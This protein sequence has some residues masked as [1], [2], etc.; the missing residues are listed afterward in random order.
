MTQAPISD[1][2]IVAVSQ[3]VDDAQSDRR[4]PSH[5]DIEAEIKKTGL[6]A[7]DPK[8]SGQTV[9]KAKRVRAV[10]N[11]AFIHKIDGGRD[12]IGSLTAVIRGHGGFRET[13]TNYVGKQV[14]ENAAQAFMAEGYELSGDGELRPRVLDN[15]SGIALT[16]ALETYVRRAKIGAHDAVLVTGTSKDLLEAVAAH[17]LQQRYGSYPATSNFPTLLGQT[18]VALGLATPMDPPVAG[19]PPHKRVERAMYELACSINQLRNKEGSGHGRP[20][21]ASVTESEARMAIESIGV[22]AERLLNLHRGG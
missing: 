5:S 7:G 8:S 1:A 2:I 15:L 22:I 11:W 19:E 20:W 10:L 14:I 16:V 13:S 4:D 3:M 9:G 6:S 18:F 12:F 17:I 21:I